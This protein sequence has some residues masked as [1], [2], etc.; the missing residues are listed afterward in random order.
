MLA[1]INQRDL[2]IIQRSKLE[3]KVREDQSS[4]ASLAQGKKTLTTITSSITSKNKDE[5]Q[6][7]I[8]LRISE[9]PFLHLFKNQKEVDLLGQLIEVI[10]A[11]Q[12][13][14]EIP[15]FR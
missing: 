15:K 7:K 14:N 4:L 10:T 6:L 8:E 11:V 5:A 12:A 2:L 9:V 3:T 1:S 13:L